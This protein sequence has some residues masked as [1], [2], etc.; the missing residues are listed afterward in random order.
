MIF[1][2]IL[3]VLKILLLSGALKAGAALIGIVSDKRMT[4]L[5]NRAGDGSM[6]LLKVA[7]SAIALFIISVA[8]AAY[9]TNRG[10]G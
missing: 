6:M 3:P 2:C 9:S 5:A 8:V 10:I 7:L 4:N 1:V